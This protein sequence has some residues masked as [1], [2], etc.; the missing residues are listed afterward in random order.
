MP[1]SLVDPDLVRSYISAG[2]PGNLPD[3]CTGLTDDERGALG[4]LLDTIERR[5]SAP[6]SEV[7]DRIGRLRQTAIS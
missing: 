4:S 1:Q 3:V 6:P 7:V 5:G 2:I